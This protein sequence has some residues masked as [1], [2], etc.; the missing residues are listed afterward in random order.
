M[1][2]IFAVASL[3][4]GCGG[5]A[6]VAPSVAPTTTVTEVGPP[7]VA[8]PPTQEQIMA[9]VRRGNDA[10]KAKD[11]PGFLDAARA[12]S[13]LSPE[14]PDLQYRL[15]RALVLAGQVDDGLTA[16]D[17]IAAMGLAY[18]IEKHPDFAGV[19]EDPR[20]LAVRQKMAASVA[21]IEG[22][23]DVWTLPTRALLVE[24]IAHD[25][26][27]GAF[28]LSM[29]HARK[30]VRVDTSGA[31]KDFVPPGEP[32]WGYFGM[33]A[34]P[35]RRVLWVGHN[36]MAH[37]EGYR[38]ADKDRGALLR[39]NLDSGT[40]EKRYDL[41]GAHVLGDLTVAR[42]GDVWVSDSVGGGIYRV[43][44]A[45]A[46]LEEM[47]PPGRLRSPQGLA[48]SADETRLYGADYSGGLFV[49]DVASRQLRKMQKP[50]T[51]SL[52]GIDGLVA[53]GGGLVAVQNGV[54]PHRLVM[55]RLDGGGSRVTAAQILDMNDKVLEPTHAVVVGGDVYYVATSQWRNFD[56]DG[57]LLDEKQTA[58]MVVRKVAV[59]P[60]Q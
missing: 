55:L 54:Q 38:E 57:K 12:A 16:L 59:G 28:F 42:N 20:F 52:Y 2:R 43:T 60:R 49:L 37:A 24:S 29:V 17:R 5:G 6:S 21:P 1:K 9:T 4:V 14:N 35:A 53:A 3:L 50:D 10:Y 25:S 51:V 22:G 30:I 39:L 44:A 48:F 40:V 36:A 7:L 18:R 13:T 23:S 11:W 33:R 32:G 41:P 58:P 26:K 45:G 15:A 56:G 46:A 19:A 34:D 27:S 47:V 31:V 8:A